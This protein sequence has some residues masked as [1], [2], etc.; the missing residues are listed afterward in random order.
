MNR[1]SID[2]SAFYTSGSLRRV[3]FVHLQMLH[4]QPRPFSNPTSYPLRPITGRLL[5]FN[6]GGWRL[7]DTALNLLKVLD[8]DVSPHRHAHETQ[9]SNSR[10]SD[11]HPF[12]GVAV[13]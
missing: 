12:Q 6:P 4:L 7:D 13:C 8:L 10:C 9:A 1:K 5:S 3:L 11:E 2:Y